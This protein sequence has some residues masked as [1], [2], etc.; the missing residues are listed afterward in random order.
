M[1]SASW[2]ASDHPFDGG[3]PRI[4]PDVQFIVETGHL[5]ARIQELERMTVD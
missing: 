1:P 4:E 3:G 2:R 5:G